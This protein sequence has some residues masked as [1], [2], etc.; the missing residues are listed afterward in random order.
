M[1]ASPYRSDFLRDQ[2]RC[3]ADHAQNA[4]ATRLCH[5]RDQVGSRYVGH[6]SQQDG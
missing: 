6:A 1:G 3:F 2:L 5:R 4:I